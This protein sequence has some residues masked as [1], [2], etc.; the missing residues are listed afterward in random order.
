MKKYLLLFFCFSC[1]LFAKEQSLEEML[2]KISKNSYEEERYQLQQENLSL[3]RQHIKRRDFQD[4]LL[5]SVEY[6]ENHRREGRN[7]YSKKGNLQRS[8]E[9]TSELQSRQY[10]VCRLLLEK[11]KET[12]IKI[13]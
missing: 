5:A 10:L 4:G 3:K 13:I 7:D 11:K 12:I 8:E 9:H 2:E 1:S 6:S